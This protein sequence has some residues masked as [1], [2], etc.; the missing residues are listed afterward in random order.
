[1]LKKPATSGGKK[2]DSL[3]DYIQSRIDSATQLGFGSTKI[4]LRSNEIAEA[5]ELLNT[6]GFTSKELQRDADKGSIQ[7]EVSW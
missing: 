5:G 2:F 1:M 3:S 4:W 6:G 7:L